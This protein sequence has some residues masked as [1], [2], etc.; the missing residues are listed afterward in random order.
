[1][2]RHS[3]SH[4]SLLSIIVESFVRFRHTSCLSFESLIDKDYSI[5][6]CLRLFFSLLNLVIV[7]MTENV[8]GAGAHQIFLYKGHKVVTS[9]NGQTDPIASE[10]IELSTCLPDENSDSGISPNDS[11]TEVLIYSNHSRPQHQI[12]IDDDTR[13]SWLSIASQVFIPFMI[14][15]CGMVAAGLVLEHV[16]VNRVDEREIFRY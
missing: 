14:A 12:L 8:N 10:S 1:M 15:G 5:R 13:E 16:K 4:L 2:W 9:T 6:F 11:D 7:R 3:S